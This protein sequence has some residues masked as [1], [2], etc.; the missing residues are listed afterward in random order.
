MNVE[1]KKRSPHGVVSVTL[2]IISI[3][4][5]FYC[6]IAIPASIIAI[7]VGNKGRKIYGTKSSKT[8]MI[9]GIIGLVI[10]ILIRISLIQSW[11]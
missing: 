11:L 7:I 4:M 8:G 5:E 6:Y 3:I 2:G 10:S 1:I 9:L